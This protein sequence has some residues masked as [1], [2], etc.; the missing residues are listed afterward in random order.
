MLPRPLPTPGT[1]HGALGGALDSGDNQMWSV[2]TTHHPGPFS[3][4]LCISCLLRVSS[5]GLDFFR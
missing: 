5:L 2:A 4:S 1:Q 3:H